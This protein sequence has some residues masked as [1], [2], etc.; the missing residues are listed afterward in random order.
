MNFDSR[1]EMEEL[2]LDESPLAARQRQRYSAEID[3]DHPMARELKILNNEFKPFDYF[4]YERYT[5]IVDP[6]KQSVGD[7]PA[8]CRCVDPP[9]PLPTT[10]VDSPVENSAVPE[11]ARPEQENDLKADVEKPISQPQTISQK[12]H[13]LDLRIPAITLRSPAPNYVYQVPENLDRTHHL[14][15]KY[16]SKIHYNIPL[17]PPRPV[18]YRNS[19]GMSPTDASFAEVYTP[20]TFSPSKKPGLMAS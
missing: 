1:Y 17:S 7:P 2:L 11:P 8:W 6:T 18:H 13:P 3:P 19:K 16:Q 9:K 10:P 4:I 15:Q 5:G 14:H 20:Q 12:V